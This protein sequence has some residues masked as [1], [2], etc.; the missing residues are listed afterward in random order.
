MTP[1]TED[2]EARCLYVAGGEGLHNLRSELAEWLDA[3]DAEPPPEES[4]EN[5]A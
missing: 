4:N 2:D 1:E 3:L 5:N